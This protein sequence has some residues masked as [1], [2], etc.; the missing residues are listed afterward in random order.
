ME[1][2]NMHPAEENY[3]WD[4]ECLN[5]AADF[6]I[7]CNKLKETNPYG[8]STLERVINDLMTELW[9]RGFS[10]TEIRS[11]F[12]SAVADMPRYAEGQERR[13]A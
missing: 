6:A 5:A 11:A 1:E 3:S 2:A 12:D 9:D 7:R 13:G 4:G 8:G 10:Q